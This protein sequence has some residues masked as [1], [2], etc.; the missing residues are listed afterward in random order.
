RHV[1]SMEAINPEGSKDKIA[2]KLQN[3]LD[4]NKDKRVIVVGTTCTGKTTLLSQIPDSVDMDEIIFPQLTPA[5]NEY[6]CQTPWT[7]EIGKIMDKLAKK[8]VKVEPGF[9]VFGTI[10]FDCDLII[11]LSISDELL[12]KRIE[13]RGVKFEDAKNMQKQINDDIEK[14]NIPSINFSVD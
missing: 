2:S 3:I 7:E 13:A 12:K 1:K 5:E 14:S 10:I 4:D 8:Y 6:V 11:N 9:P